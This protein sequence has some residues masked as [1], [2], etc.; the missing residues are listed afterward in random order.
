[1]VKICVV[2]V[3]AAF[4]SNSAVMFHNLAELAKFFL[5]ASVFALLE[6]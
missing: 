1:M 2:C 4:I 6:R 3:I 5:F